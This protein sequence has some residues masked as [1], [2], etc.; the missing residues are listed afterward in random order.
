MIVKV[1]YVI[2]M[3]LFKWIQILTPHEEYT[4]LS[5]I[6]V[7][8]KIRSRDLTSLFYISRRNAGFSSSEGAAHRQ[9]CQQRHWTSVK[10]GSCGLGSAE[11]ELL[12]KQKWTQG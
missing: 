4:I 10:C 3:K 8:M 11:K 7:F 5:L 9:S 12:G 2:E 6:E 1:K